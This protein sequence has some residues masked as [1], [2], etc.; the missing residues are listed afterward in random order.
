MGQRPRE[1]QHRNSQQQ[2]S[3]TGIP[4]PSP[5]LVRNGS[6][7]RRPPAALIPGGGASS[8]AAHVGVAAPSPSRRG[9]GQVQQQ[10]P[11]ANS[12]GAVQDYTRG[13]GGGTPDESFANGGYGTRSSAVG[14]PNAPAMS[15]LPRTR[16]EVATGGNAHGTFEGQE[17]PRK[18]GLFASLC[19][20][21]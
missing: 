6:K 9:S 19:R 10:H 11:Y 2:L 13:D 3:T 5:A 14:V 21:G 20:C 15:S 7:Q 17:E 8:A 12:T 16:E 18:R 1:R 4:S